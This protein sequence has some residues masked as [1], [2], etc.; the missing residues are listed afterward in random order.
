MIKISPSLLSCNFAKMAD[1]VAAVEAAGADWLHVDVMDGHFVPNITI[2]PVVV[3]SLRKVAKV[4]LDVHVMID[5]PLQYADPFIDAGADIYV[6]HVEADDDPRQVIDHVKG[7]GVRVGI[8]L[9]PPTALDRIVPFLRDVDL[10]MIMSVNPGF[11][12]QGFVDGSL[13]R[14]RA[15]RE[16]HGFQGDIEIDGGIK[17]ENIAEAAAAGANVFVSGSGIFKSRDIPS[18]MAEMRRRAQAAFSGAK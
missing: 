4:P 6:F 1:D 7:R 15:L 12:G 11:A 17:V 8:T 9:N 16:T 5:K 18:T 13:E 2:G 14:V 3:A 10:V